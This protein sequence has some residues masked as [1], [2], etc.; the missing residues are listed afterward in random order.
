MLMGVPPSTRTRVSLYLQVMKRK[1]SRHSNSN[2]SPFM[3]VFL[4]LSARPPRARR[5]SYIRRGLKHP[6]ASHGEILV[7]KLV[8]DDPCW[9]PPLLRALEDPWFLRRLA[10]AALAVSAT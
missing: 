8:D 6:A 9:E 1:K 7:E 2:T 5:S 4:S 3:G 10:L